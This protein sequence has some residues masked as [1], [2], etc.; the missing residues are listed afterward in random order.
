[1]DIIAGP[2]RGGGGGVTLHMTG[3]ALIKKHIAR[4]CRG[5]G[6]GRGVLTLNFGRYVTSRLGK[7][8]WRHWDMSSVPSTIIVTMTSS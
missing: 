2:P 4:V 3:Y 1:M 7:G 8:N 6:G 5:G